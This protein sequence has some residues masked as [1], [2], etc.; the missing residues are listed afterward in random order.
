MKRWYR[1]LVTMFVV[2]LMAL[3]AGGLAAGAHAAPPARQSASIS[4]DGKACTVTAT[5]T[6][7]NYDPEV[8]LYAS[9]SLKNLTTGSEE[10]FGVMNLPGSDS[11]VYTE[12]GVSGHR[13]QAKGTLG[14]TDYSFEQSESNS[15]TLNCQDEKTKKGKRPGGEG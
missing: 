4:T 14:F 13:Y 5:F 3:S 8:L 2:V 7:K 9:V 10:G 12:S 6:W 15:V 1:K 11:I